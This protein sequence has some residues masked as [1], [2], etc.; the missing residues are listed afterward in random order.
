MLVEIICFFLFACVFREE[1]FDDEFIESVVDRIVDSRH[2]SQNS[3]T[4][5][6]T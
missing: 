3:I 4:I 1:N 5:L 2:V 6:G